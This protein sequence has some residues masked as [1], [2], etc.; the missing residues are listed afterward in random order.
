VK[1]GYTNKLNLI[2]LELAVIQTHMAKEI[3][4]GESDIRVK[5]ANSSRMHEKV[6]F[7]NPVA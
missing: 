7:T 5:M 4:I 1:L 2:E 6:Q 3:M